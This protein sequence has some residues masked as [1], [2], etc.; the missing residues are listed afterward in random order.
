MKRFWHLIALIMLALVVPASVC[1]LGP[2][3]A[4]HK[5][6][7]CAVP[8]Q[9][10]DSPAQPEFCPSDTISHSELPPVVA[11]PEAEMVELLAT[12]QS[13]LSLSDLVVREFI[14]EPVE[15]TAPPELRTSWVFVSRAALPARAPSIL[16]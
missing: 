13:W 8:A 7:C 1:C 14:P 4:E 3:P 12:I 11:V 5:D 10:Q 15:T 6:T 2:Q 9:G 16:G